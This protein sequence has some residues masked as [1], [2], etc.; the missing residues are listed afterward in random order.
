MARAALVLGA[1]LIAVAATAMDAPAKPL[2]FE[3]L[4]A[5]AGSGATD[6]ATARITNQGDFV[7]RLITLFGPRGDHDYVLRDRATGVVIVAYAFSTPGYAVVLHDKPV[8]PDV[9]AAIARLEA[10]VASARPADWQTT[11]FRDR[12]VYRIGVE[13]QRAFEHELPPDEALTFLL[14]RVKTA[15]RAD[16]V[17]NAGSDAIE[18]FLAHAREL[19][20]QRPRVLEALDRMRASAQQLSPGVRDAAVRRIA[21]LRTRLEE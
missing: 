12:A 4:P 14:D 21:A 7:G 13:K 1:A 2:A 8:T 15:Q 17:F 10:L 16:A 9:T 5:S 20:A 18:Y 3:V 11:V 19:S 6:E